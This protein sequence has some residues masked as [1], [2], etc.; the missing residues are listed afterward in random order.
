LPPTLEPGDK[1]IV[2]LEATVVKVDGRKRDYAVLVALDDYKSLMLPSDAWV[3]A[4]DVFDPEA[5]TDVD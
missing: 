4:D 5:A 2:T 1:V 3:R